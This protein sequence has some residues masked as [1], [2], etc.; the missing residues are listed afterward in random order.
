[1][2][3]RQCIY[4]DTNPVYYIYPPLHLITASSLDLNMLMLVFMKFWSRLTQ[5]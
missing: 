4:M 2:H 3:I 1:M 5:A